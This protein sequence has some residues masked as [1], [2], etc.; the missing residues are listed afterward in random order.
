MLEVGSALNALQKL[1]R[2]HFKGRSRQGAERRAP[3][4]H[5]IILSA[6]EPAGGGGADSSSFYGVPG[7]D[8]DPLRGSWPLPEQERDLPADQG[9]RP[10]SMMPR[11]TAAAG[12]SFWTSQCMSP[13]RLICAAPRLGS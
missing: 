13:A 9:S 1:G 5:T 8:E 6:R 3:A 10:S 12:G 7:F 4:E 11:T 2:P